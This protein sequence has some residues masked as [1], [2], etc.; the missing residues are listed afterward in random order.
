MSTINPT[1]P[2]SSFIGNGD[3]SWWLGTVE[4][5]DDPD[6][7]LNR[8]KVNILGYHRP[9]EKPSKLPWAMV[10]SPTDSAGANG[11]GSGGN[12]LKP[13][14]FVIGFF[15]DY[16]DCQQPVVIGS[17][18]SKI[19]P[20]IKK[21]S[22]AARDY[23][24][25]F[26]NTISGTDATDT[27]QSAE[28]LASRDAASTS[29]SAA[30]ADHSA[31]N[32]SGVVKEIPVANGKSGGQKT[33]DSNVSYAVTNIVST[34]SHVRRIKK[35]TKSKLTLDLDKEEQTIPIEDSTDFPQR[36]IV[37]INGELIGYGNKAEKKLVL[38]KRGFD[39]SAPEDHEKGDEVRLILKSEYVGEEQEGT[40]AEKGDVI[41]TF[42]DA[43]VDT[44]G[45]ID[46]QLEFIKDSIWWLVNQIKSFV[47][48]QVTKILNAIGIA[49]IF[50][51]PMMGKVLTDIIMFILKEIACIMDES[52]VEMIFG[53]IEDA[54][55]SVIDTL[56]DAIDQIRCIFDAIFDAI[57]SLVDIVNDIFSAVNDIISAISAVGDMS[58]LTDIS[59]LGITSILD[60][61]F[62]LLGIGCNRDTRDPF[63]IS[64]SGCSIASVA[65][66]GQGISG[67]GMDGVKGKWNPQY[68]KIIG[69]FSESGTMVA[70]DDTPYNTRLVIEHGP[71]KSGIH[72]YDNG[73]VKVTNASKKTEVTIKD[74][75][76][77]VHGN[78]KMIVDGDYNLKVGRDYHLEVL[79]MYNV[80]ANQESK[81]TFM[82][83]HATY[84]KND[85]KLEANNGLAIVASKI[86]LSASGQ[87]ELQSPIATT[88]CTEQNHFALGSFNITSTFYNRYTV[89]N[90]MEM[91]IGNEI[92]SR[93]GTKFDT[94][95]GISNYFQTGTESEWWGG[96]HQQVG[97]GVW[98][99]NKLGVDSENTLGITQ[100]AKAAA[101][102]DLTIG[103]AFKSTTGLLFDNAQGLF[104]ETSLAPFVVKAP[105]ISIG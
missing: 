104:A 95:I 71:S 58:N 1:L 29:V 77:I 56:M 53:A 59:Q 105:I 83:E 100:F 52:L 26:N 27:G 72:V 48:G 81:V 23:P 35:N 75:E 43:L 50:P 25:G 91:T 5:A 37:Q 3:F 19:K 34:A 6:A 10:M 46:Q 31:A 86:G 92:L 82:G 8:V 36:G 61:I 80:T 67:L 87:Y 64:F 69:T 12:Q 22:Q 21:D 17:L 45:F 60:F 103:A 85:S 94:G 63:D 49:A 79:G 4:N 96:A 28:S 57:F 97:M 40:T 47:M 44:K 9:G 62:E 24:R 90:M 32:P 15:L 99:E 74:Q 70:M 14:S 11:V 18:L 65:D 78:V 7:R 55:Q 13:G 41:G 102:L 84:F 73:D 76:V 38:A 33:F 89:G 39:A 68:S 2:T 30:A 98:S 54:I 93:L 16:P 101:E 42:T 51:F 20:I 88:F 66:C